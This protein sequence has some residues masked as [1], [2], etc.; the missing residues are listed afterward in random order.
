[1]KSLLYRTNVSHKGESSFFFI[2]IKVREGE[3]VYTN[4]CEDYYLQ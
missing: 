3:R 1:M 2:I 4:L